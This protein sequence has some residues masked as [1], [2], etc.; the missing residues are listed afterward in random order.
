MP[1]QMIEMSVCFRL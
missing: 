1:L